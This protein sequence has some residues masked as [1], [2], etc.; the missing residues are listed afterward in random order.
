MGKPI[1]ISLSGVVGFPH[2]SYIVALHIGALRFKYGQVV[3]ETMS[4]SDVFGAQFRAASNHPCTTKDIK[5]G[6]FK[7]ACDKAKLLAY[8]S[9]NIAA[10]T[11]VGV[12]AASA[13]AITLPDTGIDIPGHITAAVTSLGTV[14]LAVV[15]AWFSFLVVRKALRWVR[16]IG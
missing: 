8:K 16:R 15:G 1:S 5:M 14:L 13:E 2:V 11:A 7:S 3:G 12:G 4:V 6:F 9:R 10:V